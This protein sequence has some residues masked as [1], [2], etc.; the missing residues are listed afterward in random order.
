MICLSDSAKC[1]RGLYVR[2]QILYL[3][4]RTSLGVNS[5]QICP[6]SIHK[7][8]LKLLSY[9]S[10]F[11][12]CIGRIGIYI[13]KPRGSPAFSVYCDM[14]DGGW[15][16]FMRR[17][18][19]SQSFYLDWK[20]YKEGFGNVTGEHWL[21]NDKLYYLTNQKHYSMRM[22]ATIWSTRKKRFH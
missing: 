16:V 1:R 18:D 21:G 15:T 4:V 13:I 14:T 20:Q 10:D 11:V 12:K 17:Y 6:S 2:A 5:R 22:D 8:K 19:G 3:G 9:M 7:H